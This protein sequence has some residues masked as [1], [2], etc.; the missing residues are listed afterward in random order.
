[1][2]A[3]ASRPECTPARCPWC[4][5]PLGPLSPEPLAVERECVCG[6]RVLVSDYDGSKLDLD[7]ELHECAVD[8]RTLLV[9]AAGRG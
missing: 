5:R 1:M 2:A 7:G 9:L 4:W 8:P 3:R 6:T